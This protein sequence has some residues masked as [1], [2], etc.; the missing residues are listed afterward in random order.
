M[1]ASSVAKLIA[2]NLLLLLFGVAVAELTFGTW[3]SDDPLDELGIP[4]D[5]STT[6]SAAS[7]YPGGGEFVYRRD[8]W[9]FRGD[10]DPETVNI[11]TIGGSTTNQLYVSEDR[12][13][14]AVMVRELKAAG[15]DVVV[16][17]AGIDGQSSV[18]HIKV[19]ET[20]L[21]HVPGLKPGFVLVYAGINDVQVSGAWVDDLK[22][23]SW[24]K[25]ARQHSAVVG[26]VN[27]VAGMLKAR[28][29]KLTHRA[30][31][32]AN[33]Q[34]TD[35]PNQP[36]WKPDQGVSQPESYR[37]RLKRLAV[38]IHEMGAVPVFVTQPRGDYRFKDGKLEGMAMPEGPNGIDQYRLLSAFNKATLQTCK[39]EGLLC[40]DLAGEVKFGPGDFYDMLHNTPQ[41]AEKVG[42]WLA[43]RLAG[44]V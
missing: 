10:V 31:D 13:W 38:L 23:R 17:N 39:E 27:K 37:Q 43:E 25:R 19:L 1:T 40:L 4:R 16:A 3:F 35:K 30:V 44:L 2:V 14:Q 24:Y 5:F 15:R 26:M 42:R 21:P 18:G 11:V 12:T 33:V 8:H 32:W 29:A 36:D 20:W 6:V 41:G 22:Q 7:L 9:G 34:W 28:R